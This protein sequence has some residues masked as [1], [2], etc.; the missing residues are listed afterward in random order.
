[1]AAKITHIVKVVSACK[2][3]RETLKCISLEEAEA[4]AAAIIEDGGTATIRPA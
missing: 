4:F 3:Y 1:M 2:T